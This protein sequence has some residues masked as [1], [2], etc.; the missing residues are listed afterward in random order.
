MQPSSTTY[1]ASVQGL[2]T[3][4]NDLAVAEQSNLKESNYEIL[5]DGTR[6]RRRAI[7]EEHLRPEHEGLENGSATTGYI[8][9]NPDKLDNQ[10]FL[11]EQRNR[12]VYFYNME[13]D[14]PLYMRE[15]ELF[16]LDLG[17]YGDYHKNTVRDM[18]FPCTYSEGGGALYIFHQTA[19][20]IKVELLANGIRATPVGT[21]CRDYEGAAETFNTDVRRDITQA[22]SQYNGIGVFAGSFHISDELEPERAYN[23]SNSGWD[24]KGIHE[25]VTQSNLPYEIRDPTKLSNTSMV[26]KAAM[27][28]KYPA[29]TDRYLT[30]RIVDEQGGESFSFGQ[31]VEAKD[32]KANPPMGSRIGHTAL[33]PAGTLVGLPNNMLDNVTVVPVNADKVILDLSYDSPQ[34]HSQGR[35][36]D[37]LAVFV[38]YMTYTV[39]DGTGRTYS[40]G[41]S[42]VLDASKGQI[43]DEGA[44][45]LAQ[46]DNKYWG[47]NGYSNF[48]LTGL[49]V[50]PSPEYFPHQIV[51]NDAR[52]DYRQERRPT[53]GTYFAGRL[54]Q[55]G[56]KHA[57]LY[58]SQQ[59]E[60][61]SQSGNNRGVCRESLCY[62]AADPTDGFD[63]ALVATDGGYLNLSDSGTH[64]GLVPLGNSLIVLTDNGIWR[65]A[66]GQAGY[67]LADDFRVSQISNAEVLGYRA[68]VLVDNELHIATDEGIV[69]ITPEGIE[70]LTDRKIRNRYDEIMS[71][72]RQV[73]AAYDPE[74]DLVR[75]AFPEQYGNMT[76]NSNLGVTMLTYHRLHGAWFQYDLPEEYTIADM[77]VIPYTAKTETYNKFRYLAVA[78]NFDVLTLGN[79]LS[80]DWAVETK[81]GPTG[82]DEW[83]QFHG[84]RFRDF[85]DS[86]SEPQDPE[87]EPMPAYMLTNHI[88]MGQGSLFSQVNY[89]IA[90]NTNVTTDSVT[91]TDGSLSPNIPG[92]TR[93]QARWDWF[94]E[95]HQNKYSKPHET[96]RFRRSYF[97]PDEEY[98]RGEPLLVSKIKVRGRGRELRLYWETD[99][100]TD[101]HITGWAIHGLTSQVI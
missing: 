42:G 10:S 12:K 45:L 29:L 31:L 26:V 60:A 100:Q 53:T 38:H 87:R 76:V 68:Y 83:V 71:E 6:R 33:H 15:Q 94:N 47:A 70:S 78:K 34:F 35:E 40:G 13:H 1:S 5:R 54:W 91:E 27:G 25:F 75:W 88:L 36:E 37:H 89:L 55:A 24:A 52:Y 14:N 7:L 48:Q 79:P 64:Y 51:D 57:R 23:L 44:T 8:W 99:L 22:V 2:I 61:G 80:S 74:T 18:E 95:A 4:G 32:N 28:L 69:R 39:E 73:L 92:S 41:F 11:V 50:H 17:L 85:H 9:R 62:A 90:F 67:F 65:I 20:T 98:D 96:Y 30:G 81:L 84:N 43:T 82:Y 56:D 3:D 86:T 101:S 49:Y 72:G 93:V 97:A 63:N 59:V 66:P 21:W 77:V 16:S 58:Y 19:G 46:F